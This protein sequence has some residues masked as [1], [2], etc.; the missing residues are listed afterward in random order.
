MGNFQLASFKAHGV[1]HE[2]A[3]T[4]NVPNLGLARLSAD[5]PVKG[6]PEMSD[7]Y[8]TF[9]GLCS[10]EHFHTWNVKR[11]KLATFAPYHLQAENH[12][13]LLSLFEV[14]TSYYDDL[15]L[16][17][18]DFLDQSAYF[19]LIEKIVNSVLLGSGLHK[20]S[21]ADSSVDAWIKYYRQDENAP[22]VIVSYYAKGSLMALAL[23]LT[24]GDEI[25]G[26]KS[27]E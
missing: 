3:I 19:K 10:H 11:I 13:P 7:G 27:L 4:G 25:K 17:F 18:S 20:Q 24:I 6:K 2:I 9:L 15:I 12:T 1:P 22:N 23:D 21:V 26:R 16:F 14:F 5:L 8:R